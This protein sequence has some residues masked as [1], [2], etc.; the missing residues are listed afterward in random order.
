MREPRQPKKAELDAR[1]SALAAREADLA[2]KEGRVASDSKFI[3]RWKRDH[4][5]ADP[6]LQPGSSLRRHHA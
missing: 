5:F 3:A 6:D 1:R 4:D 2:A